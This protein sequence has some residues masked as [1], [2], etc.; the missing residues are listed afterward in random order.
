[1]DSM[2]WSRRQVLVVLAVVLAAALMQNA[3]ANNDSQAVESE[4]DGNEI[5]TEES[6]VSSKTENIHIIVRA[7]RAARREANPLPEQMAY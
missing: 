2:A 4:V 7:S 1:M 6:V 3:S 5:A